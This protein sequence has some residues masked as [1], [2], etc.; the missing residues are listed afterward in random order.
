MFIER[1]Q[2]MSVIT[3]LKTLFVAAPFVAIRDGFPEEELTLPTIAV[4]T[5]TLELTP[6]ELGDRNRLES[7]AWYVDIF[8][9]NKAQRD[10]FGYKIMHELE[11]PI[12][13]YDYDEGFP[14]GSN[15]TQ[16]GTLLPQMIQMR[17]IKVL[18]EL[19]E[20]LYYRSAVIFTTEYS[21]LV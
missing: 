18:P 20:A 7:R 6:F 4:E 14:V 15:P 12:P 17:I 3:W 11:N 5:D 21:Q 16:I 9:A 1:K 8:A 2:D 19:T 13:V 10:E